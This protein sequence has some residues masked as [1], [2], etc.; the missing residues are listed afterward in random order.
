M[1]VVVNDEVYVFIGNFC[2][3]Y[4]FLEDFGVSDVFNKSFKFFLN[5]L[6]VGFYFV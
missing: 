4:W 5:E 2:E 6:F 3:E 1:V